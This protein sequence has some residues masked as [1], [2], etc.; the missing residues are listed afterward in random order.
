MT[1]FYMGNKYENIKQTELIEKHVSH[2]T[3]T[4]TQNDPRNERKAILFLQLKQK[5]LTTFGYQQAGLKMKVTNLSQKSPRT[6]QV[7][8][9]QTII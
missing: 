2:A 3:V 9:S 1:G 4:Y 8:A 6:K 7:N 5:L